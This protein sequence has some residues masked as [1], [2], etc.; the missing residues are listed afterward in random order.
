MQHAMHCY[1]YYADQYQYAELAQFEFPN[2]Y[3]RCCDMMEL[4]LIS[5]EPPDWEHHPVLK[6]RDQQHHNNY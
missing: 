1:H 6:I 2:V 3:Q 5:S 4:Y